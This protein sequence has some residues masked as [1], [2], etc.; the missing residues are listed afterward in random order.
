MPIQGRSYE[1]KVKFS[2]HELYI[3][4]FRNI[5]AGCAKVY[6]EDVVRLGVEERMF[7]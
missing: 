2:C 5:P 6:I 4:G 7:N 1:Y 3:S